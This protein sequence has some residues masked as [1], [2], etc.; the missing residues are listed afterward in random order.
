MLTPTLADS[1]FL[2]FLQLVMSVGDLSNALLSVEKEY[3]NQGITLSQKT[4]EVQQ[5]QAER[6][7]MANEVTLLREKAD[8]LQLLLGEFQ[9]T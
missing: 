6:D 5:A 1:S 8:A 2:L 4:L 9:L 3:Q 7:A